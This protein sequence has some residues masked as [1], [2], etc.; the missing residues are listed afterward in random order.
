MPALVEAVR[1]GATEQECC[2]LYR[3]CFGTYTDP[4]SF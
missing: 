4:G 2:D 3:E 1:A